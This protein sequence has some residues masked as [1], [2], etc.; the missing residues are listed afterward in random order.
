MEVRV[1]TIAAHFDKRAR[2]DRKVG[3]EY[4][5]P[6]DYARRNEQAG[7]VRIIGTG[8]PFQKPLPGPDAFKTRHPTAPRM[9]TTE[10]LRMARDKKDDDLLPPATQDQRTH[11]EQAPEVTEQQAA[12]RGEKP[13][14]QGN[15]QD[16]SSEGEPRDGQPTVRSSR[17]TEPSDP[18]FSHQTEGLDEIAAASRSTNP[19]RRGDQQDISYEGEERPPEELIEVAKAVD[20]PRTEAER[21]AA[22]A[23]DDSDVGS[24][25]DRVNA[26]QAAAAADATDGGTHA[27]AGDEQG[28][29]VDHLDNPLLVGDAHEADRRQ[30]DAQDAAVASGK[31]DDPDA[32]GPRKTDAQAAARSDSTASRDS[33]STASATKSKGDKKADKVIAE[34]GD[35]DSAPVHVLEDLADAYGFAASDIKKPTGAH[36]NVVKAD[37]VRELKRRYGK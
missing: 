34:Y 37:W 18:D 16:I 10:E 3:D 14:R 28:R 19:P 17:G 20:N 31:G 36:G 9:P 22:A 5:C 23:K 6:E 1:R 25:A 8:Q 35:L 21:A 24:E 11:G 2:K 4:T 30:A 26:E 27:L 7:H 29:P 12:V 33:K 15:Q 13:P 32:G